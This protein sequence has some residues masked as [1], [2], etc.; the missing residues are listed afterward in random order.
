MHF[1]ISAQHLQRFPHSQ[2]KPAA[3]G[4]SFEGAA[5]RRSALF[6]RTVASR[7]VFSPT[8]MPPEKMVKALFAPAGANSVRLL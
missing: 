5:A 6:K 8:H 1:I 2:T 4:P 7:K 3:A